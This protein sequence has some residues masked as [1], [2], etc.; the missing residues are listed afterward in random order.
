MQIP[1]RKPGKYASSQPEPFLTEE[2]VEKLKEKLKKL[3]NARPELAI[4]VARH[5]E[6]GDFSENAEYQHAKWQL[7]KLNRNI[8][9]TE[10][11]LNHAIIIQK[12]RQ[13]KTVELTHKIRVMIGN[14]EK[15]LQILGGLETD[16]KKGIISKDSPVG[17]AL[18]GKKVGETVKIPLSGREVEYKILDI[19]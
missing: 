19:S 1:Y 7:R 12:P 15:I 2:K 3:K 8:E 4:E 17:K 13:N 18:L 16:P 14:E 9:I 11:R 6:M 5:A 10:N